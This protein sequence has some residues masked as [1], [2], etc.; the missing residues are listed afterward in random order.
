MLSLEM[1]DVVSEDTKPND[2][3]VEKQAPEE[4]REFSDYLGSL[5]NPLSPY[6]E[7]FEDHRVAGK[8]YV[9]RSQFSVRYDRKIGK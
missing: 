7:R 4:L 9:N 2:R 1:E 8:T 6:V 3:L 5:R